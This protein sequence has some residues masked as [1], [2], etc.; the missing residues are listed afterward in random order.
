MYN[1]MDHSPR[2]STSR[3]D[4]LDRSAAK[5]LALSIDWAE[6]RFRE[7]GR[8]G[9]RDLAIALIAAFQG[10]SLLTNTLR[11]PEVLVRESRRLERWVDSLV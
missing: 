3:D 1:V 7:M 10:A 8:S 4:G 9:A 11:D 5:L 6:Q 2:S